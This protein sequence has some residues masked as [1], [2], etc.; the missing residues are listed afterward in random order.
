MAEAVQKDRLDED[1][2][3]GGSVEPLQDYTVAEQHRANTARYLALALVAILG[4]SIVLQY[5]L[6]TLLIYTGK[7]DAI[8]NL[9]KM[10]N[11][12]MPVLSG[13]VGGAT[14]YY[15]TKERR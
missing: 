3:E 1:V 6:V 2:L 12:L 14:T 7:A 5:A 8:P 13:L 4:L 9:D 11:I 15:F 10:F